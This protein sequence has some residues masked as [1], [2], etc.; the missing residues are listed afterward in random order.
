MFTRGDR[1]KVFIKK[2]DPTRNRIGLSMREPEDLFKP[3]DPLDEEYQKCYHRRLIRE[4][5]RQ[6][7]FDE[8]TV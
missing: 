3:E 8:H 2:I 6:A 5:Q 1:V 7:Y 4:A